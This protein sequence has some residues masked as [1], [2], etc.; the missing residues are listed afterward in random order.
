MD[1]S[2]TAI[3]AL[4]HTFR[5]QKIILDG[6]IARLYEVETQVLIRAVK[7]NIS[8]FPEDF[9]FQI[10]KEEFF[11]FQSGASKGR[12]GMREFSQ[13]KTSVSAPITG[14]DKIPSPPPV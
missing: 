14:P 7:R 3:E 9:M 13:G 6:D 4:I 8:R 12:G 5:G 1:R 11:R 2:L 10:T